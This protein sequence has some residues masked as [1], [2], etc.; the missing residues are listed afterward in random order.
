MQPYF[1]RLTSFILVLSCDALSAEDVMRKLSQCDDA[2]PAIS[3]GV[4][5]AEDKH[6]I[7][8]GQISRGGNIPGVKVT[9]LNN[10]SILF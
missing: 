2:H 8:C 4:S 7:W 3:S 1:H 5:I 6:R 10:I 9:N